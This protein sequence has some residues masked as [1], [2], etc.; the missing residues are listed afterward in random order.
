MKITKQNLPNIQQ[1]FIASGKADKIFFDD[2]L[3]GFGLRFRKGGRFASYCVQYERQGWQKRLVLGNTAKLDPDE[4][5]KAARRELARITLGGDPQGDKQAAA[6][7]NKL[8]LKAVAEQFL[9]RKEDELRASSLIEVTRHLQKDWKP[10]HRYPVHKIERRNV[11]AILGDIAKRGKV[12]A[13]RARTTLSSLFSF[14]I[15]EG[16]LDQNPVIGT[17]SYDPRTRRKRVLSDNEL[18]RVWSALR[19]DEYGRIVKLL[20]LTGQRRDEVGLMAWSEL[21]RNKGVWSLPESRTKNKRE[22]MLTLPLMCW[23]IIDEVPQRVGNDY[24]FGGYK[25]KG[26]TNWA[27]HKEALDKRCKLDEPWV[28]HDLRRSAA[29]GMAEI[30]IEPHYIEA[31]LNHVG[32]HKGGVAGTYN[33]AKYEPQIKTALAM[34]A[35]H[36]RSITTGEQRKV[37]SFPHERGSEPA[38]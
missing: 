28:L 13:A 4:A 10:L 22:H 37:I 6:I 24:L 1:A 35:D 20:M 29:T 17:N 31:A 11:A 23:Q 18:A 9:S 14:A 21:N 33:H 38:A 7:K 2:D 3:P 19:D 27:E 26:F 12:T 25:G 30:G 32:G 34:W 5:R 15:E 16:Y 36:I 8:T